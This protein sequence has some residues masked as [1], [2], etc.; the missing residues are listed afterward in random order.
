MPATTKRLMPRI[1]KVSPEE[2]LANAIIPTFV[3]GMIVRALQV[4]F[5]VELTK[6]F[7]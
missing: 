3:F 4:L 7:H 1:I 5:L 6:L 2:E